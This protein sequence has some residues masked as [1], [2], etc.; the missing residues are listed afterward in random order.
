MR[1]RNAC[2]LCLREMLF[3]AAWATSWVLGSHGP[4]MAGRV[5]AEGLAGEESTQ[6]LRA[7]FKDPPP[8]FRPLM[9]THS[10]PLHVADASRWFEARRTGGAVID[11]GVKPGSKDRGGEQ[12]NNPTYLA[13]RRSNS[14]RCGELLAGCEGGGNLFGSMTNWDIRAPVRAG[15]SSTG[16]PSFRS[17]WSAAERFARPTARR[18]Q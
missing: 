6:E 7:A 18:S 1:F 12:W 14:T 9:I 8:E 17:R 4:D 5:L 10:H 16:I 13:M 11:A 15:A 3:V 2:D